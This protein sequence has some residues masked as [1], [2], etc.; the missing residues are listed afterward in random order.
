M[1][2]CIYISHPK[3]TPLS[4]FIPYSWWL[5]QVHFPPVSTTHA[6]FFLETRFA[7]DAAAL[8]APG[9]FFFAHVGSTSHHRFTKSI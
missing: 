7:P 3:K 6:A 1:F 5:N 4:S 8:E 9:G 2:G